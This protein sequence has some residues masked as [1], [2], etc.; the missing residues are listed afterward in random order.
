MNSDL[1]GSDDNY[2]EIDDKGK[3]EFDEDG[4]EQIDARDFNISH[5]DNVYPESSESEKFVEDVQTLDK[6]IRGKQ[7][8]QSEENPSNESDCESDESP[9]NESQGHDQDISREGRGLGDGEIS[10]RNVI[11]SFYQYLTLPMLEIG[12]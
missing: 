11:E 9:R 6:G 12:I 1:E 2:D 3:Y 10:S 5:D 7:N 8:E 4:A